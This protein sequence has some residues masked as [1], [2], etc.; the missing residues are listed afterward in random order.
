M[1]DEVTSL[2]LG[3]TED[4]AAPGAFFASLLSDVVEGHPVSASLVVSLRRGAGDGE[5][6][7]CRVGGGT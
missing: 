3:A 1:R 7:A 6:G 2:L 4:A 5:T